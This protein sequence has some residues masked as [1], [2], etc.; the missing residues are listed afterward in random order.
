VQSARPGGSAGPALRSPPLKARQ[1][2][3]AIT[4][5]RRTAAPGAINATGMPTLITSPPIITRV[6]DVGWRDL[7]RNNA[8]AQAASEQLT[9][10][11]LKRIHRAAH[12]RLRTLVDRGRRSGD[13]G[14]DV[15]AEWLVTVFHALS[16]PPAT[17]ASGADAR[18]RRAQR[19][20]PN[21]AR[22]VQRSEPE[23]DSSESPP[24]RSRL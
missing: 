4:R 2:E 23:V 24:R 19:P 18:R 8:I 17:T 21:H 11:A 3:R 14:T 13:F 15:P 12:R 9:A 20:P 22:P 7:H 10:E 1:G 6:I 16:T 5:T